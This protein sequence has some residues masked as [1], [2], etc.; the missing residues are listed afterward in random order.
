MGRLRANAK[1]LPD[2]KGSGGY[3]T[4]STHDLQG[5]T[6]EAIVAFARTQLNVYLDPNLSRA[7]L[8]LKLY[9]LGQVEEGL[10]F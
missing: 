4:L 7:T 9:Q 5:M 8:L 6:A 1:P 3:I 2:P 10:P